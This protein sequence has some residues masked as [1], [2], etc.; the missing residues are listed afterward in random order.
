MLKTLIFV[1]SFWR[2]MAA[3]SRPKIAC[4]QEEWGKKQASPSIKINNDQENTIGRIIARKNNTG[5][6]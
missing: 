3:V 2:V 5:F 6:M 4:A 1:T